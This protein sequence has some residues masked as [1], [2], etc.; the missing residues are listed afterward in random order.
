[1]N[2]E[3]GLYLKFNG[4]EGFED[5]EWS[6]RGYTQAAGEIGKGLRDEGEQVWGWGASQP[7]SLW[8]L[9]FDNSNSRGTVLLS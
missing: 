5:G 3:F 4:Q 7:F 9:S 2:Q 6:T 8:M 1:M